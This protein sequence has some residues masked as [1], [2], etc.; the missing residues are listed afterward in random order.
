[1]QPQASPDD[2]L[3]REGGEEE[4]AR[5]Q[6]A[7]EDVAVEVHVGEAGAAVAAPLVDVQLNRQSRS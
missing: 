1:M 7:E 4:I 6:L 2:N 5:P 3:K